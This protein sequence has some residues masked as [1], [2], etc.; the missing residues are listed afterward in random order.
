MSKKISLRFGTFVVVSVLTLGWLMTKAIEQERNQPGPAG[1]EEFTAKYI[2]AKND[3]KRNIIGENTV[4]QC[5]DGE[6]LYMNPWHSRGMT[7]GS[8]GR[9]SGVLATWGDKYY[10][11]E[12]AP[13]QIW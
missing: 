2:Q 13:F 9:N 5:A 3:C 4:Y 8:Q 12:N 10:R 6:N 7:L 11:L 1:Y